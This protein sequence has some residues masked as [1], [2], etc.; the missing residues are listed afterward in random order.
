MHGRTAPCL[1]VLALLIPARDVLPGQT[2]RTDPEREAAFSSLP[3]HRIRLPA[4]EP[5][6]P[7]PGLPR[8]VA[9][10]T[11]GL[12]QLARAAGM[13]FSGTVTRTRHPATE[14]Q[15]IET[16]AITFRVES[17]IRGATAGQDLTMS[18]WVGL[19]SAGQ[20][21]RVGERALLFLY[22][23]SRLGLTSC[24][25]G[26]IGRFSMDPRGWV[27]FSAQQISAF[28]RDP[29]LG[30]KSRVRFRDFAWAVRQAAEEE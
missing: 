5:G 16:V 13:I 12:P 18:Q 25:G 11:F 6:R 23:A 29:V 8:P 9:P 10:G 22:P 17:A 26:P 30:G 1:L 2:N 20:R 28:R 4:R 3:G 19:W 24:V 15:A 27:R 7:D 14:G 21:Y